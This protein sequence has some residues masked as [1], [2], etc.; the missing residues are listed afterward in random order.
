MNSFGRKFKI[1]IFGES[2]GKSV[3]VTIDG[4][5]AGIMLTED[6]FLADLDRRRSGA[7]GTTP[8]QEKDLPEIISGVFNGYST[9]A[10]ITI[11]F[12]NEDTRS[13]DYSKLRE[14]PR[15]GHADFTG[16]KKFNGFNDFRGGGHFSA[17]LTLALVSAGVI[18]KKIVEP[19]DIH[20]N[21]I[22]V[23]G[24]S[25]IDQAIDDAIAKGDSV[26]GIVECR[27]VNIPIG[28]GEPFFDSVESVIS[29][30]VF[31]I[32]AIKGIEF[33]SGF[34]AAEMYGSEHTDMIIDESGKTKTNYAAG[35]NGG[36]S[37][38]NDLV[39]RI[40]V[41]P[42]SSIAKPQDTFNMKTGKLE[43]L[44]IGGRHDVCVA[45]RVPVVL[46]AVTAIALADFMLLEN[47]EINH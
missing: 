31:A 17:R 22:S 2:H 30:L 27:S 14:H 8:R 21:L 9:G 18:A 15:P 33:G 34:K 32:P 10:P 23:N 3:G 13:K 26:G 38:G 5:P 19:I 25:N 28:L 39:F 43:E 37:N 6:D 11:I 7:K 47:P 1:S 16:F 12:K 46:E 4:C 40:A 20:T 42:T 24:I 45:L 35:I 44:R 36:I 41:K 29:H